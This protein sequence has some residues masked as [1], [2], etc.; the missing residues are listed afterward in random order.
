MSALPLLALAA[1]AATQAAAAGPDR[2][3]APRVDR[4]LGVDT[5][6]T[7][8]QLVL[9][10]PLSDVRPDG[11]A[12][13]LRWTAANDW[14]VPTRLT[15]GGRV[16]DVQLDE[17]ADRLE[18]HAR[19]P[20]ARLG[21]GGWAGDR[22]ESA[23]SW[24]VIE[25]W[26]GYGD[27]AIEAWHRLGGFS[28]FDRQAYPRDATSIH[29]G[30]PGGPRLVDLDRPRLAAG[31]LVVRTALRVA[32]GAR[33]AGPWAVAVR[34]D[35][36]APLG[37]SADAG[38]SGGADAGLGLGASVALLPW[39]TAHAQAS[40]R[41]VAPLPGA[42]PL[43]LR[44]WQL[45][46]EASLVAWSGGW[47]LALESRWLSPLFEGGWEVVHPPVKGDALTALTRAQNQVTGGVRWR[48]LTLWVSEDWTPGA[49]RDAGW[50]WFYDTNA[51]DVAVGIAATRPL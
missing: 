24:R 16:V 18:V 27:G 49:R 12:I 3:T 10:L 46:A 32:A 2:A 15:R 26:G 9:D 11:G 17:Q 28:R 13:E 36:K 48:W 41:R 30:V 44:P 50:T 38:G 39:L 34:L 14:S 33:P 22:L 35:L 8:R 51:P 7:L 1:L 23:V 20:W 45:G 37:R 29:L 47:A 4:P 42:V 21:A 25:H 43:R 5:P 31:D 6:G 40:A 19:V